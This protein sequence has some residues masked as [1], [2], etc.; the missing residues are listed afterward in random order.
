MFV[1]ACNYSISPCS[2]NEY[3][4]T[5][6]LII[7][8]AV[9]ITV[10]MPHI[11]KVLVYLLVHIFNRKSNWNKKIGSIGLSVFIS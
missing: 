1:T 7:S 10:V 8:Y 5:C 4:V 9:Q 6:S 3:L 2:I 11:S